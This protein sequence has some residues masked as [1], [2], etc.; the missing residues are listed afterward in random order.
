MTIVSHGKSSKVNFSVLQYPLTHSLSHAWLLKSLRATRQCLCSDSRDKIYSVISLIKPE[1]RRQQQPVIL[2][3]Y[4]LTTE[5]VYKSIMASLFLHTGLLDAIGMV[6][7]R[8]PETLS[9]NFPSWVPNFKVCLRVPGPMWFANGGF[10]G[11]P[12]DASRC[13]ITLKQYHNVSGSVLNC[14]GRQKFRIERCFGEHINKVTANFRF[15]ELLKFGCHLPRRIDA[16]LRFKIFWRTLIMDIVRDGQIPAPQEMGKQFTHFVAWN[17]A[18]EIRKLISAERELEELGAL[19]STVNLNLHPTDH[20]E[21]KDVQ[22]WNDAFKNVYTARRTARAE[23]LKKIVILD[24]LYADYREVFM[25]TSTGRQIMI[26]EDGR[27]VMGT[28]SAKPGDE[29]WLLRNARVLHILRPKTENEY[30]YV[31]ECY[32]YGCMHGQLLE[33]PNSPEESFQRISTV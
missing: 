21:L 10:N 19:F 5:G 20:L 8:Q 25:R 33:D 23:E 6:E 18:S 11:H 22:T 4:R 13:A 7:D 15:R 14:Q 32:S 26:T 30:Q 9:K 17:C 2:S 28:L 3:D 29:V 1:L 24:S 16:G 12:F 31:G 27:L